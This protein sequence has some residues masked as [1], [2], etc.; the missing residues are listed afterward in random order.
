[1]AN[2]FIRRPIVAIVIAIMTVL[3]GLFALKGLGLAFGVYLV[4]YLVRAMG[5]GD[6]KLMI[7]LLLPYDP[8]RS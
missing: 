4:L 8:M 6:V 7:D 1:M 5:A 2:F 3:M